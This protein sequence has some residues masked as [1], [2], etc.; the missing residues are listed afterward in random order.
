MSYNI[1]PKIGIDGEREFR[2][3]IKKIND[4]YKALETETKA[5]T[6]AFDANGDEQGRV[7]KTGEL[8]E[9]QIEQ[10]KKKYALLQDAVEKATQKFGEDAVETIRLRGAMFDTQAEISNLEKKQKDL[11]DALEDS[12]DQMEQLGEDAESAGNKAAD[13]GDV[14]SASFLSDALHD[15][16]SEL[17]SKLK[18]I[19]VDSIQAAAD[20]QAETAQFEQTFGAVKDTATAALEE[21]SG[22]TNIAVT[23][24]QGSYTKL[25]AFAKTAGV[26]QEKALEIS[27]RALMAAADSAAYYDRSIE[28][29]L[30]SLQAFMKGNFA[31]DAALGI[32]CTETTRNAKANELYAKSFK[33]LTEAQKVDTLLAMVE[34]GNAASGALGQAA[35]ESDAWTN[36]TGELS[37]AWRQLLAK[38]GAPA[39]KKITPIVQDITKSLNKI[40]EDIDW[41]KFGDTLA[42]IIDFLLSTMPKIVK[43]LAA[44]GAGLVA[45]KLTNTIVSIIKTASAML[46]AATAAKAAGAGIKGM[47]AAMNTTPWGLF[48]TA[49]GLLVSAFTGVA[50]SAEETELECITAFKNIKESINDLNNSYKDTTHEIEATASLAETYIERLRALEDAGLKTARAQEEYATIV[51]ALNDIYPE[52]N[53][54]IDENTGLINMSTEAVEEFSEVQKK[55]AQIA[56][57]NELYQN[58]HKETELLKFNLEDLRQTL[59]DLNTNNPDNPIIYAGYASYWINDDQADINEKIRDTKSAIEETEKL[60]AKNE[61]QMEALWSDIIDLGDAAKE[62]ADIVA[63]G[64]LL[65]AEALAGLQTAYETTKAEAEESLNSQISLWEELNLENEYTAESIIENW[66][67]Q[68]QAFENYDKN[69]RKAANMGMD[70]KLL[71]KLNDGSAESMMLLDA[72]VNDAE[73]SVDEI[74]KAFGERMNVQG[75]LAEVMGAVDLLGMPE[76]QNIISDAGRMGLDVTGILIKTIN[77]EIAAI[78]S[79]GETMG[80]AMIVGAVEGLK[81]NTYLFSAAAGASAIAGAAAFAKPLE[82]NSPSKL[83]ERDLE[84]FIDGGV[85]GLQKNAARL[86]KE[87]MRVGE[88]T[89]DAFLSDKL[90]AAADYISGSTGGSTYNT[91]HNYG[92][93]TF[94]IYQREGESVDGVVDR[95]MERIHTEVE[96]KEAVFR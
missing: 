89:G 81:K 52:L 29:A 47:A 41:D 27:G 9:K 62:T 33:E 59:Q 38:A 93:M 1:G 16:L 20:V 39:L 51:E 67:K 94:N 43:G 6:A 31:N 45:M 78:E 68:K 86:E 70:W 79:S 8:L 10:Q 95:V 84:F 61:K 34:A 44:I 15:G 37:E 71:Q 82:I 73:I 91:R 58:L 17:A 90:M 60:I 69:L 49:I 7:K 72:L 42:A 32:A 5:A 85:I 23:R 24:L 50:L 80:K 77:A 4:T 74:N 26:D 35:R 65:S 19:A 88:I 46:K 30:E 18:E 87:M 83:A 56:A 55:A 28:A 57:K 12:G 53:L 13:F 36:V 63:D 40:A 14:L 66:L 3:Q 96:K 11:A 21:I 54:T 64:V 48:A 75:K 92:G 76:T 22:T 2:D 25:Y